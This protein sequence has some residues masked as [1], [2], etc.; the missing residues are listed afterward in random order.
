[1]SRPRRIAV[2]EDSKAFA[3]AWSGFLERDPDLEIVGTFETAEQLIDELPRLDPDLV[4][5][6]L[7]LPGIDGIEATERIMRDRP[8]PILVVSS[9]A[10]KRS[11]RTARALAA[12]A[13]DAIHKDSVNIR[14]PDD[15]WSVALRSRVKRLASLQ[16]KRRARRAPQGQIRHPASAASVKGRPAVLV[17]IGASTG[18]PPALEAVL[19]CLPADFPLPVV[20][21]QHI[22]AGFLEGLVRWLD[23]RV[24]LP[25]RVAEEGQRATP[26][27]WFAPDGAHLL[28]E[29]SLRFSLDRETVS[30][31]H[32][33]SVDMLFESVAASAGEESV[34]VVLTGMGRDGAAGTEAI[35]SAG[36]LVVAQDEGTSA[37]YGM[38]RAAADAGADLVL[39]LEEIGPT[40]RTARAAG[41]SQR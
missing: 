4:T 11:E 35:R 6:D 1:V 30:G 12:G 21:V 23:G 13:L 27:I 33:P 19:A 37:V 2:C 8:T 9:H 7:E 14:E 18:G 40:I 31:S 39:P 25:V 3:A 20:V 41:V 28:V 26:G 17:A 38:P 22:S 16:L 29:S 32:R 5:M 24:P 34:G 10:G 15:V 36:G